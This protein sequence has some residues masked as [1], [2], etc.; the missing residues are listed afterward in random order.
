[1]VAHPSSIGLWKYIHFLHLTNTCIHAYVHRTF[2]QTGWEVVGDPSISQSWFFLSKAHW[3]P[4]QGRRCSTVLWERRG[5]GDFAPLAGGGGGGLRRRIDS[6]EYRRT[7]KRSKVKVYSW[8]L[9][10][11]L[12]CLSTISSGKFGTLTGVVFRKDL[13]PVDCPR[14]NLLL[15]R[16]KV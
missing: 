11:I 1:M 13:D 3:L 4:A 2:F 7:L 12:I 5:C 6:P 9:H 14:Q 10:Y 16:V 15:C 8:T